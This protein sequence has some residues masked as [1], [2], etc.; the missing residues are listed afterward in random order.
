MAGDA[1]TAPFVGGSDEAEEELAADS[2]GKG[3]L[4]PIE[5]AHL[6]RR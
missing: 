5:M 3:P 4:I 2:D 1:Q 6:F